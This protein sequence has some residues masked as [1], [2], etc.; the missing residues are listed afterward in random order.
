MSRNGDE[1]RNATF[2]EDE[3]EEKSDGL[4]LPKILTYDEIDRFLLAVDDIEDLVAMRVMLFAG[5]RV[6]EAADVLVKDIDP[7]G[8]R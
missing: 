3:D 2:S 6:S 8:F 1:K 4:V 7:F 5:L